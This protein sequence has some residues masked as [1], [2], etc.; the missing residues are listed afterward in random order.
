MYIPLSGTREACR[1]YI[2]LLMYPGGMLGV[3]PLL[4]YPGGMLGVVNLG[5]MRRVLSPVCGRM[6]D[7]EAQRGPVSPKDV[8]D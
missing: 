7:N 5:I 1:V 6:R 3:V 4:M 2:P 8:R